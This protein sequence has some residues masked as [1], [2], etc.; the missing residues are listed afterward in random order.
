MSERRLIAYVHVD[1]VA[2]G[3]DDEIPAA[4]AKMIGDHAWA[5]GSEASVDEGQGKTSD[6]TSPPPRT[7]RGSGAEAWREFAARH[8]DADLDVSGWSKEQVISVLEEAGVIER[9]QPKE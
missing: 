1:G 2:Y 3:P 9:E 5:D 6:T 4:V 8:V 7:G